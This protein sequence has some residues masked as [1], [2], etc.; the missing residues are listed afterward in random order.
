MLA[1]LR[2]LIAHKGYANAVMLNAIR[3]NA[4]TAADQELWDLLHHVFISN[5][6][7]LL[8]VLG[9]PFDLEAESR[10]SRSFDELIAR[11]RAMQEQEAAW[12]GAARDADLERLLDS[13]LI[14][15]TR[16]SVAQAWLQVCLHSHG[17]RAQCAKIIRRLGGV[18]PLTDFIVWLTERP[19]PDWAVSLPSESGDSMPS[20]SISG[21][22]G[23]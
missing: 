1:A 6:F 4:A 14:P 12:A 13:P 20:R 17:H 18:P 8:A 7:W 23:E 21:S 9:L 22:V 5:R 19:T 2:D 10:Q 15:G 11:Y 3:Q 16:C